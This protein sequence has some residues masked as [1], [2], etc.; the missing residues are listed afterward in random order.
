M[1]VKTGHAHI[2]VRQSFVWDGGSKVNWLGF[3]YDQRVYI[4]EM[5]G[6][7]VH[8]NWFFT[9]TSEDTMK[10]EITA[11]YLQRTVSRFVEI[12]FW[13]RNEILQ[14]NQ[15]IHFHK[16][17]YKKQ[18]NN[19]SNVRNKSVGNKLAKEVIQVKIIAIIIDLM[20]WLYPQLNH[21]MEKH[22][23]QSQLSYGNRESF[24]FIVFVL[25]L[26]NPCF[27]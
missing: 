9:H 24:T 26:F 12:I 6:Q 5:I 19:N 18:T 7:N 20:M 4:E 27:S 25:V 1:A 14:T 17:Y 3:R 2:A 11:S 15:N 16:K 21:G 10:L 8:D 13:K 22:H 23:M